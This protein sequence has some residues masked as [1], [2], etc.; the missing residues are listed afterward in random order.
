MSYSFTYTESAGQDLCH[1]CG[2]TPD[3]PKN[4]SHRPAS[5]ASMRLHR[6]A[7][8]IRCRTTYCIAA[9][10]S[11]KHVYYRNRINHEVTT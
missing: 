6:I 11:G 4:A 8:C 9:A 7:F 2:T 10:V 1:S 5:H 3:S